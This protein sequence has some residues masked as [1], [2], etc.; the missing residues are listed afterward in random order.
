MGSSVVPG[1]RTRYTRAM[2]A[3]HLTKS[4]PLAAAVLVVAGLSA[5]ASAP[6]TRDDQ[7][8]L[9]SA[10]AAAYDDMVAQDPSLI[11]FVD[12]SA[13]YVVFPRIGEGGFIIG[14]GAGT[15]VLYEGGTPVGYVTLRKGSF[16]AQIGGYSFSE[17]LVLVTPE[18]LAR[19]RAGNFNVTADA[20]AT[21][22][23]QGAAASAS[24]EDGFSIFISDE[25]GLMAQA[26]FSGQ[27]M[28][29]TPKGD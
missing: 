13:G 8:R 23:T 18:A 26:S 3:T 10:A 12:V 20:T 11:P 2:R 5:C 25:S 22:I 15:G 16:G 7:A 4:S 9:E 29:F 21:A 19:L 27:S 28:G 6:D 17:L 1:G 14:G 24:A